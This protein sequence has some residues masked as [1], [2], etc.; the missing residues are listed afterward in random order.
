MRKL[1]PARPRARGRAAT[2]AALA[3]LAPGLVS[4]S[5]DTSND[6]TD[7]APCHAPCVQYA[8]AVT[9][10]LPYD[11]EQKAVFDSLIRSVNADTEISM[12]A[13]LGDFKGEQECTTDY[14]REIRAEFDQVRAPLVYTPGD[15]DW[16]DCSRDSAGNY[17]P[18]ERLSTLR[19][20]FF[21]K[22]GKTLG[23]NPEDVESQA[24]SGFPENVAMNHA[25]VSIATFHTVGPLNGLEHWKGE[26]RPTRAQS[27]EFAA[28]TAADVD[29]IRQTFAAASERH[30]AAVILLTQ[31]D[32]FA[33]TGDTAAASKPYR[34]IVQAIAREAKGFAG[35]VY[36]FNGDTHQYES[37]KPL[38]ANSKWLK[39]YGVPEAQNFTRITIAGDENVKSYLKVKIRPGTGKVVGWSTISLR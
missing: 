32:M 17:N 38:A 5:N 30:D 15:N 18:L 2:A 37:D 24:S 16:S 28:R 11:D 20:I 14:Y 12:V 39:I 34:R 27:K 33:P 23:A 8:F 6:R 1:R 26:K 10:D 31:A 13:H 21:D 29:F 25:G 3:L 9:G 4:C 7:P 36:L 35:T 22:P 19:K